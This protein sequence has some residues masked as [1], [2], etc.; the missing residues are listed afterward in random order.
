MYIKLSYIYIYIDSF[1]IKIDYIIF[2]KYVL[3]E[4]FNKF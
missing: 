4:I 2:Y 1:V 3:Y